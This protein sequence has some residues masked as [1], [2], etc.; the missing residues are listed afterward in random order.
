MI[1]SQIGKRIQEHRCNKGLTQEQLAEIIGVS[2][3]YMSAVERGINALS[4]EKL[5]DVINVFDCSADD[6]F[7]DVINHGVKV[8]ASKLSESLEQLS[9][10]EQARIYEVLDTLIKTAKKK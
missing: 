1:N 8:K 6:L 2:R 4:Y 10:D 7:Q 9:N 3:N 5:V